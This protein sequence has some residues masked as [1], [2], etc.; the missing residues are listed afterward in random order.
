MELFL[1]GACRFLVRHEIFLI[2]HLAST[3]INIVR[4]QIIIIHQIFTFSHQLTL[5]SYAFKFKGE[6]YIKVELNAS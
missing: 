3:Q 5:D 4:I 2:S 6:N 1:D